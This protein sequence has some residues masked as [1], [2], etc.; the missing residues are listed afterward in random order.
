MSYRRLIMPPHAAEGMPPPAEAMPS[1]VLI[2]GGGRGI[3]AAVARRFA[4]LGHRVAIVARTRTQLEAVGKETG[5][6]PVVADLQHVAEIEAAHA[7]VVAALGPVDVL[8][9]NAGIV[10]RHLVEG[11]AQADWD[12]VLAVNLTAPFVFARCVVPSMRARGRGRIVNVSSISATLASPGLAAYGASKAGL[13]ALT[14]ALALEVKGD[15]VIV[16]ALCPGSVDT[17]ML[18][19]SGFS[20][21][22]SPED[23]AGMI[24]CLVSAPAAV[25]GSCVDMFG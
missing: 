19:G 11:H 21:D 1:V 23:V 24:H 2:T 16:T 3:G 10:V 14:R 7:K 8:I 6:L 20:P 22:M 12:A 25:S 18:R 5:A 9:N 4:A 13:L 15:G 17:E